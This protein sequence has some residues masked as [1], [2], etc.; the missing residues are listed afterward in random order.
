MLELKNIS[1]GNV[2][3]KIRTTNPKKFHV[4]PSH[5]F[6]QTNGEVS[7]SISNHKPSHEESMKDRF[8]VITLQVPADIA[9]PSNPKEFTPDF[10]KSIWGDQPKH[11]DQITHKLRTQTEVDQGLSSAEPSGLRSS[12][13]EDVKDEV[14]K[15]V[16]QSPEKRRNTVAAPVDFGNDKHLQAEYNDLAS[17]YSKE[18]DHI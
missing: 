12:I 1:E 8:Q 11:P 9:V 7:V 10:Y 17:R 2:V 18:S 15:S 14:Y 5:G 4:E 13:L 6:L 3:F 16:I